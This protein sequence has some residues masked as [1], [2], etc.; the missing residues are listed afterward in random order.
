MEDIVASTL[1]KWLLTETHH[2]LTDKDVVDTP[3]NN[4]CLSV[5]PVAY[6]YCRAILQLTNP[7]ASS[8][9][10]CILPAM[11]LLRVLAELTL[12]T[13]WSLIE[14]EPDVKVT[15]WLKNSYE[16]RRRFLRRVIKVSVAPDEDKQDFHKEIEDLTT[17]IDEIQCDSTGN[18]WKCIEEL[19]DVYKDIYQLLY[20]PFHCGIHPDIVVLGGT[21]RQEENE[22]VS[23][24]DFDHI[25]PSDIRKCCLNIIYELVAHIRAYQK[26]D[27]E[28]EILKKEH[29]TIIESLK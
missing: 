11:G 9:N 12:R 26:L 13:C 17:Y 18:L 25:K 4:L 15:R 7:K 27:T 14:P 19:P 6:T 24:G 16:E 10:N 23:L 8:D 3:A 29:H 5:I 21:L 20:A 1:D 2:R 28:L 22:M